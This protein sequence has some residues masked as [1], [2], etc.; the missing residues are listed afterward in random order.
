MARHRQAASLGLDQP[1]ANP[2]V[3]Y[4][5]MERRTAALAQQDDNPG[6]PVAGQI[7]RIQQPGQQGMAACSFM[8]KIRTASAVGLRHQ[9]QARR[10]IAEEPAM[11]GKYTDQHQDRGCDRVVECDRVAG[12]RAGTHQKDRYRAEEQPGPDIREMVLPRQHRAGGHQYQP[13][14]E[15]NAYTARVQLMQRT[16]ENHAIGRV[17]RRQLVIGLIDQVEPAEQEG[18][19]RVARHGA[20]QRKAG[21]RESE[22]EGAGDACQQQ[23]PADDAQLFRRTHKEEHEYEQQAGAEIRH[24]H[25]WQEQHPGIGT[26]CEAALHLCLPCKVVGERIAETEH[27]PIRGEMASTAA[28]HDADATWFTDF[29]LWYLLNFDSMYG[30][31]TFAKYRRCL[32]LAGGGFRFGY[33]LGVHAAAEASGRSPDLLLATCGGAMAA[34][35]ITALPH[36]S[37][38]LEWVAGPAMYHFL[39]GIQPMHNAR[40]W[41]ALRDAGRRWLE[42]VPARRIPDLFDDYLFELPAALPLPEAPVPVTEAPA[43]AIVGARLLFMPSEAG[44]L[45]G[46]RRL[47]AQVAFCPARAAYLLE[48]M[49]APAADSRWSHGAI[50]P[51]LEVDI[52]MPLLDAVRISI[53]DMFYFRSHVHGQH[54]YAGGA[55]DLFPIELATRLAHEVIMERKAPFDRWLAL[56]ALRAVLGIHGAARLNHVHAQQADAWVDTSGVSRALRNHSV[57]KRVDWRRNR[58]GLAIP[59]THAAYAAQVRAQWDYGYRQGLAAFAG[60]VQ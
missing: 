2:Q 39:C 54:H 59:G 7:G 25:P 11:H 20:H 3:R 4:M 41:D 50:E 47:F 12:G 16:P 60:A 13:G 34:A 53:T 42:R 43:L 14:A 38:R 22:N 44:Q 10:C 58:I 33:Y 36:A 56:P 5:L 21:W 48:G 46:T 24:D 35:V 29:Y 1:A 32:V 23:T 19:Q 57:G 49:T 28:Q 51:E 55:I 17:E 9:Q 40:A 31:N 27:K 26:E 52:A 6:Q 37:A 30:M 15:R 45:R 8:E 18:R